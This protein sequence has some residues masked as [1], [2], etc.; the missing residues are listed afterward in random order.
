MKCSRR[1]AVSASEVAHKASRQ[2][3]RG[4]F[5]PFKG[6]LR[7]PRWVFH[8]SVIISRT[9]THTKRNAGHQLLETFSKKDVAYIVTCAL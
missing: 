4:R 6:H 5:F 9:G 7:Q 3:P 8:S 1:A 2:A